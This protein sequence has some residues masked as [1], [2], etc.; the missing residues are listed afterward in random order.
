M[1]VVEI[2]VSVQTAERI[3]Q[4]KNGKRHTDQ[5]QQ[6]ITPHELASGNDRVELRFNSGSKGLFR[7]AIR[8]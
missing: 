6:Q 4:D 3:N 7:R 2:P 1:T 5:P 8:L